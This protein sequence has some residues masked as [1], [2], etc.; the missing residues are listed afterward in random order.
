MMMCPWGITHT[1]APHSHLLKSITSDLMS[2]GSSNIVT[3]RVNGYS[4]W[5]RY[6]RANENI[7]IR[8]FKSFQIFHATIFQILQMADLIM[9]LSLLL[10]LLSSLSP[11]T[12]KS[13]WKKEYRALPKWTLKYLVCPLIA[14]DSTGNNVPPKVQMF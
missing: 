5:F 11:R 6:S 1:S 13:K 9:R 12:S 8:P 10:L 4:M 7:E 14:D 3:H 2:L